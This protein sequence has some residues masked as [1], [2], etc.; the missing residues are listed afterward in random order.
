MVHDAP[1]P[2]LAPT[3]LPVSRPVPAPT[4]APGPGLPKAAPIAPPAAAPRAVPAAAPVIVLFVVACCGEIPTCCSAYCRH[5]ASSPTKRSKGLPGAGITAIVG[6]KGTCVQPLRRIKAEMKMALTRIMLL[7]STES[8]KEAVDSELA[9]WERS[10]RDSPPTASALRNVRIVARGTIA[11]VPSWRQCLGLWRWGRRSLSNY[12]R[13]VKVWIGIDR[14]GI[15]VPSAT[16]DPPPAEPGPVPA[17]IPAP[18][19]PND[20]IVLMKAPAPNRSR[21]SKYRQCR[22]QQYKRQQSQNQFFHCCLFPPRIF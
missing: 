6:P 10:R 1:Y 9:R 2:A 3:A 17:V 4:A 20:D 14:C 13:S 12:R 16:Y 22:S 15:P 8:Y 18:S 21:L 11:V 19:T 5:R 7:S